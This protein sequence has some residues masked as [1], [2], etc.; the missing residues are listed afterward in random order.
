MLTKY[1]E[2]PIRHES[3]GHLEMGGGR[4]VACDPCFLR[5]AANSTQVSLK[6][7]KYAVTCI[8]AGKLVCGA[9]LQIT[10]E[11][12]QS[13]KQIDSVLVDS[14]WASFADASVKDATDEHQVEFAEELHKLQKYG[15]I[16]PP[17]AA[18]T[19][20]AFVAGHGDGEYPCHMGMDARG[21]PACLLIDFQAA[22]VCGAEE[23]VTILGLDRYLDCQIDDATLAQAGITVS[24]ESLENGCHI[25]ISSTSKICLTSVVL[26]NNGFRK[27][28]ALIQDDYVGTLKFKCIA[29]IGEK[30]NLVISFRTR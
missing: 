28:A 10:A 5:Y 12:A 22:E 1:G 19:L 8:L 29:R 16:K 14:G 11:P 20:A 4:V 7:G 15:I 23:T 3:V 21:K 2:H 30:T 6:V 26:D 9:L 24:T 13:W 17:G 18:S 25:T 27:D